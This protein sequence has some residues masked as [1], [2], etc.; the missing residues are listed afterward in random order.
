MINEYLTTEENNQINNDLNTTSTV[1][2]DREEQELSQMEQELE[3]I[4]Q[5]L[6]EITSNDAPTLDEITL[7]DLQDYANQTHYFRQKAM[8]V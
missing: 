3:S 2:M 7:Q 8:I 6:N 4:Q 1:I 5:E